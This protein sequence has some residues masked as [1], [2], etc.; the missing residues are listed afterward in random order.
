MAAIIQGGAL[1]KIECK[2]CGRTEVTVESW[3]HDRTQRLDV[4]TYPVPADFPYCWTCYQSGVAREHQ[5]AGVIAGI[6]EVTGTDV[7]VWNTG[8]GTMTGFVNLFPDNDVLMASF[9]IVWD[10]DEVECAGVLGLQLWDNYEWTQYEVDTNETDI[11]WVGELE[12]LWDDAHRKVNP[13]RK[14]FLDAGQVTEWFRLVW[15][16]T[17]RIINE[18]RDKWE[19]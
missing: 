12:V 14:D 16:E 5:S 6:K 19:V 18:N 15:D 1:P 3:N 17:V 2:V 8:G 9:G 4:K 11:A 13:D 7:N 10:D